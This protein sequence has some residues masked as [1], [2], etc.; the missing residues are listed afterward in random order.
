MSIL[1]KSTRSDAPAVTASRAILTGLSPDGGLYVPTEFPK[2]GRPLSELASMNYRELAYE[3]MSK[4]FT[5]FTEEE[6]RTCIANAYDSKFDTEKIAPLVK[7]DGVY[8]LELYHGATIAF[9]DM[10]LSI[11]P[12]LMV[13]SARKNGVTND[14][15]ILTATSGD[16]GKAAMAGFADVPGTKIIVFYP[17]GGVSNIQRLQMATQRG[18]NTYVVA[19]NGNF[20]DAQTAVKKMTKRWQRSSAR[21][22]INSVPRTPSISDVWFRRSSTMSTLTVSS[23]L[24]A[25][26]GKAMRLTSRFRPET[27]ATFL[28]LIMH[29][30]WAFRSGS[31]YA[32][33]MKTK[34]SLTSL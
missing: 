13:T 25:K 20:D 9:K 26:S 21:K 29:K 1:Y 22:G 14:I 15:V 23:C 17:H 18:E 5:D 27:S 19:I 7:K 2:L 12:H 8:Y 31:L 10:A 32:H 33:P 34:C 16:T 24:P 3:I 6:L 4:F 28:P 11:L 30:R